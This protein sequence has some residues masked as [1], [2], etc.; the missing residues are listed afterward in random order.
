M[1]TLIY[2]AGPLGSL[3]ACLMHK[4]GND[5]TI[6]AR[7]EHYEF[8]K[9]NGIV[10]FNEFSKEKIVEKVKVVDSLSEEDSYE[11]VIVLMR[12]NSIKN[13]L[14]IL[15]KNKKI[16]NI[17]FMGN[18]TLGFDEYLNYL[19]K[20]KVLFGFPGGGGSRMNHIVHYIDS[21]KPN[22][23][24][25]S[26]TIGEIDGEIRERTKQIQNL[27]EASDVPV[28]IVEDIDGWLKYHIAFVIPIA[29]ALLKC[30]DNYKLA[31]DK[32]TIRSYIRAAKEGG[33]VLKKI[34]YKKRYP[35][36]FNLFYWMPEKVLI[37][38][39]KQLFNSKFA[40]IAFMLHLNAAKDEVKE[41]ANE[42][43]TLK[44]QTSIK[45]PNLDELFRNLN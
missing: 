2:G 31:K 12:K 18:N 6:L 14:P 19:P 43:K 26:I 4:A 33:R 35:F 5:V 30:G 1:K 7:N 17:L 13:V 36:K 45:T 10:M 3:Y 29:G 28:N 9:E 32:D 15:C 38:I 23:K 27:F 22:G 8:L 40:E 20:E 24:R 16:P 11:L 25:L 21:E 39:M 42:F 34:G 44:N 37:N 41:L